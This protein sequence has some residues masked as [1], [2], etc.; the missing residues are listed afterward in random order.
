MI[1]VSRLDGSEFLVNAELIETAE[2]TPDT[3]L[4]LVDGK[5]LIIQQP[6]DELVERIIAYRRR[7]LAPNAVQAAQ[8]SD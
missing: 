5:K 1:R 7:I 3:V 2:A 8:R 6:L 4:T